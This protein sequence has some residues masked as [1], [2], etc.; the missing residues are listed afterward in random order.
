MAIIAIFYHID[1]SMREKFPDHFPFGAE[2]A[3]NIDY[4]LV[5]F[6]A[7]LVAVNPP[8]ELVSVAF[9]HFLWGYE[10]IIEQ[11]GNFL[12]VLSKFLNK[13]LESLIVLGSS[14]QLQRLFLVQL[15]VCSEFRSFLFFLGTSNKTSF[16]EVAV[17][18]FFKFRNPITKI[19][20]FS[21]QYIVIKSFQFKLE[22]ILLFF[23]FL[24][25]RNHHLLFLSA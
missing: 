25:F 6:V 2:L 5:F 15:L 7:E 11:F 18:R 1:C 16:N 21:I 10:R 17:L 20:L 12:P 24:N 8:V 19:S 23:V 13:R 14:E 3:V 22:Y 9:L 4:N